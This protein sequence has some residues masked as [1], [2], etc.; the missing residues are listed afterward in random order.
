MS[1]K[2]A[3]AQQWN[4]RIIGHDVVEADQL[5]ANPNNWR[6]HPKNQQEALGS[7]LDSV[8]WVQ[9]VIVN[10][11][12][13]FVVDGHMRAAL[14]ISKGASVPVTYVDLSEDEEA[15]IL[16]SFDPI[17]MA[18]ATDVQKL[19]E[20]LKDVQTDSPSLNALLART[21][22]QEKID[23]YE[24]WQGMP[25][26]DQQALFARSIRINFTSQ[27]DV[28]DFAKLIGQKITDKT[29]YLNYPETPHI[30]MQAHRVLD[31]ES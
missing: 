17:G 11:R 3:A 31:D 15:L 13:G 1:K 2:S 30:V 22:G 23:P 6:I 14:A 7:V 19:N 9:S 26:F 25:E 27:A 21:A 16:A 12:T 29:T 24:M 28:D 18:A 4:N 20:L 10:Q 8:G 5:L